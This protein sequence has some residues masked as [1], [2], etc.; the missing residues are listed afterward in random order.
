MFGVMVWTLLIIEPFSHWI[1]KKP[2]LK[3][4]LEYGGH[5]RLVLLESPHQ[6]WFNNVDSI[7]L[8]PKMWTR[9]LKY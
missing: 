1:K 8:R 7:V 5:S 6:V 3:N 9:L 4:I 2:R